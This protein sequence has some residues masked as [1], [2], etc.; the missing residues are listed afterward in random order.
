MACPV[1]QRGTVRALKSYIT[2]QIKTR[3]AFFIVHQQSMQGDCIVHYF[4]ES[5]GTLKLERDH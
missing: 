4:K 1:E 2:V 3:M 5:Y